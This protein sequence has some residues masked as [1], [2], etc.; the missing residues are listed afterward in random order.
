[1]R[2]DDKEAIITWVGGGIFGIV[3]IYI[4]QGEVVW[5]YLFI[6]PIFTFLLLCIARVRTRKLSVPKDAEK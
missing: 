6:F 4:V 1:M 3:F 5:E 2:K